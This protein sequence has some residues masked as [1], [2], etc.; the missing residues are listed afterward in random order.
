MVWIDKR[1]C[2]ALPEN[3]K[4]QLFYNFYLFVNSMEYSSSKKYKIVA[5]GR[6]YMHD[7]GWRF[8][9]ERIC[10]INYSWTFCIYSDASDN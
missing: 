1:Y 8:Q 5:F 6:S 3:Q 2:P 9:P 10:E 7:S 4:V